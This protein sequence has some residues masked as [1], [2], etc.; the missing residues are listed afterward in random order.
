MTTKQTGI[1]DRFFLDA[2]DI[3]GDIGAIQSINNSRALLDVTGI[4]KDAHERLPGLGDS[5]LSFNNWFNP[6]DGTDPLD[7]IV[8]AHEVL[9]TLTDNRHALYYRGTTLGAPVAAMIGSQASYQV[10]R[11][12]DGALQGTVQVMNAGG[13]LI[14]WGQSLTIGK[15][16]LTG[17]IVMGMVD[18]AL[19]GFSGG[20]SGRIS[21]FLQVFDEDFVAVD[22]TAKLRHSD[23][24]TDSIAGDD[25]AVHL[26]SNLVTNSTFTLNGVGLAGLAANPR[27]IVV[28]IVDTTPSVTAGTVRITGTDVYGAALIENLNIAAGAGTYTTTKR[29]ASVTEVRTLNDVVTLGGGGDETIKVGTI[30]V[31]SAFGDITGGAFAQV[32]G[33]P[34]KQHIEADGPIKRYVWAVITTSGGVTEAPIAIA[35]KRYGPR[36]AAA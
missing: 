33:A 20:S 17:A 26:V 29:Y 14:E 12:N 16:V 1:G 11:S 15:Q 28:T 8:G 22:F 32:T 35:A 30:A 13:R 34:N 3:S 25:D 27:R 2:F 4:D 24:T 23:Y 36:V 21:A 18:G 7:P 6:S 31:A 10:D 19:H 5:E 9:K